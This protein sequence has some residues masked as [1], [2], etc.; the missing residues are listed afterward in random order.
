[1]RCLSARPDSNEV[2]LH[3]LALD[4][5]KLFRMTSPI[6]CSEVDLS[7]VRVS[8]I[9]V[10]LWRACVLQVL[11]V[12]RFGVEQGVREDGSVKIRSVDHFSWSCKGMGSRKRT[13]RQM[14]VSMA[15][16][17]LKCILCSIA[18]CKESSVNGFFT[19][20]VAISHEHLDDLLVAMRRCVQELK[21]IPSL[22]KADIDAAF[23]R[24]PVRESHKWAA[25]VAYLV[26]GAAWCS[27]HH[28]MPF[29]ATSSVVAWHRVGALLSTLA[30]KLL[31]IPVLRYVDDFFAPERPETVEHAMWSFTRLVRALLGYS[32]I[33]RRKL[34]VGHSLV[35]LGI[36]VAPS[37]DGTTF[38]VDP[39]KCIKWLAVI[40]KAIATR[41]LCGGDATKLAGRLMWATQRLFNRLGRAMIKPIYAQC[42]SRTGVADDYLCACLRWWSGV[43]RHEISETKYWDAPTKK[44]CH[45]FVDAGACVSR[46]RSSTIL[47]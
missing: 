29:G 46:L 8:S 30:R 36:L 19:P 3:Q 23:R 41:R 35:V 13:R 7:K 15:Y 6:L 28:G 22:F 24:V 5:A 40:D 14:K 33:A 39:S 9:Y 31:H 20:D 27:T 10:W 11:L 4:D 2:A 34:E 12:P 45:L 21:C 18:V 37:F 32:A 38:K 17:L 47:A 44:V 25:S 26:N 42:R 16:R 1:M 43:L